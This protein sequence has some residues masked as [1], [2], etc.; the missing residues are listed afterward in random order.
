MDTG[1]KEHEGAVGRPGE[2]FLT[3]RW[4]VVMA[5]G[6]SET[7][8]AQRA[9]E[10]IC[11]SYWFPLYAFARRRGYAR[12]DAEDVT[13]DFFQELL[14]HR[15]LDSADR[16]K[17]RLRSFLL[18]AFKRFMA[19]EWR[20]QTAQK[21]GGFQFDLPLDESRAEDR[22]AASGNPAMDA[23]A[24]FD[25]QW[26]TTLLELTTKKLAQDYEAA[27]KS[28]EFTLLKTGLLGAQKSVDY[29]DLAAQLDMTEGAVRVAMHRLRKRFRS[30]YR[31]EVAETLLPGDELEDELQYLAQSMARA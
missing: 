2:V 28:A 20:K 16:T 30:L 9:L 26:A 17:G 25:T 31:S 24:L 1:Q 19:K 11:S 23:E 6:D 12:A 18:T 3:T 27:G 10:E 21:R 8:Q 15:W 13:Q 5:A 29:A 4:T 14:T 7:L 22:Y